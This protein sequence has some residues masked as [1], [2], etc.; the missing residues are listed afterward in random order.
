MVKAMKSLGVKKESEEE[1]TCTEIRVN[2]HGILS[3][4]MRKIMSILRC[5]S[6]FLEEEDEDAYASF[7]TNKMASSEQQTMMAS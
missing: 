4:K 5:F 1:T 3:W 2:K 7:T 6:G